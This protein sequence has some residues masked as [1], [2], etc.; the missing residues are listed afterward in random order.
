MRERTNMTLFNETA[1]LASG[2]FVSPF[3]EMGA[4]EAMW[5]EQGASFASIARRFAQSPGSVPSDFS[6]ARKSLTLAESTQRDFLRGGLSEFKAALNGDDC[7]PQRLRDARSP[8][9]MLY[10]TGDWNLLTR[11]R[12]VAVVGTRN[13]TPNALSAARDLVGGMVADGF[14]VVSGLAK[15]VDTMAHKTAIDDG[16]RTVAVLGT[17]LSVCYP[18]DNR[19][20]QREIAKNHLLVSQVPVNRWRVSK[21][22]G[23]LFFVERDATISALSEAVVAVEAKDGSGTLHTL[24]AA[25]AQGRPVFIMDDCFRAPGLSWPREFEKRGAFRAAGWDDVAKKLQ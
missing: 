6:D 3:M 8:V 2:R 9:E 20:L 7:Y 14:A 16:G 13:P 11:A 17:P 25:E 18:A 23:G 4:Y 24:R 19:R 5:M 15:G 22:S 10:G 1:V 21:R 12:G